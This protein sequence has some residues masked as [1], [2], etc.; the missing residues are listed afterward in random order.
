MP[1]WHLGMVWAGMTLTSSD[2]W[3]SPPWLFCPP[4]PFSGKQSICSWGLLEF[5]IYL[6]LSV[7]PPPAP[8]SAC[9]DFYPG[10]SVFP[11]LPMFV[12]LSLSYADAIH[13]EGSPGSCWGW[14]PAKDDVTY[15]NNLTQTCTICQQTNP[16]IRPLLSPPT[17]FRHLPA[18][19]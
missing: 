7:H 14:T 18:Q 8:P 11:Y 15:L 16:N 2:L 19:D 6:G 13:P 4:L 10:L 5:Y 12:S 1:G 17:K 3:E 9:V